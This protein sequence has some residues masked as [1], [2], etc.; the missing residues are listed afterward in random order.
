[1]IP[2]KSEMIPK[3]FI[4]VGLEQISYQQRHRNVFLVGENIAQIMKSLSGMN[5]ILI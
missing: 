5:K 4:I 2:Q 3:K 1:M